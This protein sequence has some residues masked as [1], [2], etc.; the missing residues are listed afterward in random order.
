MDVR[1]PPKIVSTVLV[2]NMPLMLASN[3][4][5]EF[6]HRGQSRNMLHNNPDMLPKNNKLNP[7]SKTSVALMSEVS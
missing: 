7:N 2:E 1:K 6:Y 5:D 3:A 4:P